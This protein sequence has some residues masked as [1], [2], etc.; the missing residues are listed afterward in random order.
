MTDEQLILYYYGDGLERRDRQRIAAAIE[1]DDQ[2]A[3]R[4]A[5]LCRQLDPL[6]TDDDDLTAPAHVVR[7]MHDTIDRIGRPA[8]VADEPARWRFRLGSFAWGAAVTA[9]LAIGVGIGIF[10][11]RAPVAPPENAPVMV[12]ASGRGS[13]DRGVQVYFQDA[14]AELA[15][16]PVASAS[17]RSRLIS[18]IIEQNRLFERA[19]EQHDARDLARVLRAF[20]PILKRLADEDITPAEAEALRAQLA[21]EL[22]VMLTKISR[23]SSNETQ[24]T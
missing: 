6:V 21:F 20:E 4:Y 15:S 22:N 13:F 16:M 9:A 17:D 14:R 23:A 19:A 10:V 2:L 11:S 24:T 5:A 1:A 12:E 18:N 7:R 3:A 8:P